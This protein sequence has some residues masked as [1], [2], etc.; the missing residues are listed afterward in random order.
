M[1]D[2]LA[3]NAS[4]DLPANTVHVWRA[5]LDVDRDTYDAY[6]SLLS[7]EEK[8]RAARFFREKDRIAYV[9]AHGILR[10]LL[11]RYL[12]CEPAAIQ[13]NAGSNGKPAVA[14]P[15]AVSF[16]LSHSH[17][18]AAVAFVRN[19]EIGLDIEKIRPEFASEAVAERFFSAGEVAELRRLPAE[20]R[21]V[22]FFLCWTRKEA[23]VKALSEGLRFPLDKFSVSLT[24]GEPVQL[25]AD[26]SERW[27]IQSFDASVSAPTTHVG[28]VVCEGK[29]WA[30]EILDW[31]GFEGGV[32]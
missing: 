24:P 15:Q 20:R 8:T 5:A 11:G 31:R 2:R 18:L 21:A 10:S 14:L 30:M 23:Y 4:I 7:A 1:T 19:R 16:N 29:D 27:S 32:R 13:F 22:G 6:N 17:G 28:A 9:A 25:R 26:D 12:G 3:T